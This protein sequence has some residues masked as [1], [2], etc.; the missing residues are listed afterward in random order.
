MRQMSFSW[1]GEDDPARID[2]AFIRLSDSGMFAH[3]SSITAL[4]STSWRLDAADGWRTRTLDVSVHSDGWSRTLNLARSGDGTWTATAQERG[5]VE[6]APA[7]L[8]DAAVVKGAVD[9]DL[10]LCPVTNTMP[11][12]RLRLLDED[13]SEVPLVM[14]WVDVP[15]LCVIRSDQVYGSADYGRVRYRSYSRDFQAELTVD[16]DGVVIDYPGLARRITCQ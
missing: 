8:L 2:H 9:C 7:G 5:D 3:G 12:R 1:R 15:S 11:I 10:G 14:A 13:V 16:D 6:L 4:Y